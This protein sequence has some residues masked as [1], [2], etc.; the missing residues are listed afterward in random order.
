MKLDDQFNTAVMDETSA[1][2]LTDEEVLKFC[3]RGYH[4]IEERADR[5][6]NEVIDRKA[7]ALTA[8][9][10][11]GILDA[12]PEL[13]H[14][15]NRPAVRGPLV[16]LLGNDMQ[17]DGHRHCHTRQPTPFSHNWHTDWHEH[18][19]G[20]SD[21]F[22]LL[23]LYYPQDVTN[24]MGPTVIVPGTHVRGAANH[25]IEAFANIRNQIPLS[26]P[27][28]TVVLTHPNIWHGVGPNRSAR[29]RHMLKF[30]FDRKSA[31]VAPTWNHDADLTAATVNKHLNERVTIVGPNDHNREVKLRRRMWD[32]LCGTPLS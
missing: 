25:A 20:R 32:Y 4:I 11:D 17:M 9:P 14:V 16:S 7:T 10:G 1:H 21:I 5:E 18:D 23:A 3:A 30:V 12:V 6:L 29:C 19:R 27:A 13:L 8:N 28:G 2:L 22:R 31:P 26:M 15:F 24:D